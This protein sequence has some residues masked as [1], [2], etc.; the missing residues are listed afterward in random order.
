MTN[1]YCG[2]LLKLNPSTGCSFLHFLNSDVNIE[3]IKCCTLFNIVILFIHDL[4]VFYWYFT[5]KKSSIVCTGVL[6]TVRL[7][8][9]IR[10]CAT[11][12]QKCYNQWWK[13]SRH[14]D[15]VENR[16][17]HAYKYMKS[18]K[19]LWTLNFEIIS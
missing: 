13:K 6:G 7:F 17:A 15:D 16:R 14:V 3:I 12:Y 10:S 19:S 11:S 4:I 9:D 8:R 1:N 2:L 5:W 18:N